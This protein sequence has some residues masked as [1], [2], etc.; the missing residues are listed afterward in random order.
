MIFLPTGIP[1]VHVIEIKKITDDRG[2][3]AR[4]WCQRELEAQGL[5]A[6]FV[7]SNVGFSH[8]KGTVR[9]MHY[10]LSPHAEV[11][12]VC[13]TRGAIHDV[14][15]DLRPDSPTFK[16]SFGIELSAENHKLLYLPEGTA[17]GYQTLTDDAEF[18]YFTTAFYEPSAARGARYD[19][20]AFGIAW[21][22]PASV[23]SHADQSWPDFHDQP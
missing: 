14:G 3:F 2:F 13:C 15:V 8:K 9:G 6:G 4:S 17:H 12:L 18:V 20:P 21:P 19:D 10:Q 7:Q 1:G 5:K 16:K 22:L 23:I 11:K